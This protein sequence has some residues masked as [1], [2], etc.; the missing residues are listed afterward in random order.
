MAD[1]LDHVEGLAV[2]FRHAA[3]REP[4]P[5]DTVREGDGA[6]L[7]A[8]WRERIAE[9]LH[10]LAVAWCDPEAYVGTCDVLPI[11]LPGDQAAL[12]ALDEVVVHGWDLARAT[13]QRLSV[14]PGDVA[15]CHAF[16]AGFPAP[17]GDGPFGPP[18]PAGEGAPPLDRL[19]AAT[20]RQP[21]WSR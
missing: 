3:T 18:V 19:V 13:G 21:G 10:E 7:R 5:A 6:R 1:L 20:G 16:V 15:A 11:A 2:A 14:R 4:L 12:V 17:E 9:R 8:G